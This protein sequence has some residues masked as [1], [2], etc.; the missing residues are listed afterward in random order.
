MPTQ[1]Q[2][3]HKSTKELAVLCQCVA[4][5]STDYT[6]TASEEAWR[7]K[8]EWVLLRTQSDPDLSKQRE[9]EETQAA[10]HKRMAEFLAGIL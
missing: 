4:D 2:L 3:E 1:E 9:K 10:L 8:K 6:D 7:L 5:H